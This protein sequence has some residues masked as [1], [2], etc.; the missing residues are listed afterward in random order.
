V[1][2][3]EAWGFV[4]DIFFFSFEMTRVRNSTRNQV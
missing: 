3:L 1:E 4:V 2:G